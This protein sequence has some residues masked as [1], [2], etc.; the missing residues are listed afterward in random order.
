[1]WK[2]PLMR[3]KHLEKTLSTCIFNVISLRLREGFTIKDISI[4][5][6]NQLEVHVVLPWKESVRIA[7]SASSPWPLV[8][9]SKKQTH[10][11]IQIEGNYNLLQDITSTSK[12]QFK[13]SPYRAEL[14]NKY[15]QTLQ[16]VSETDKLLFHLQSF[17]SV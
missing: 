6:G 4:K 15:W 16:G 13:I 11:E 2:S 1:M 8:S 7:Y 12:Q 5:G 9:L 10:V 14:I 17:S 3:I